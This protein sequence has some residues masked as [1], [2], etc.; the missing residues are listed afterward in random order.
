MFSVKCNKVTC[1]IIFVCPKIL[2]VQ[3]ILAIWNFGVRDVLQKVSLVET[4]GG[5]PMETDFNRHFNF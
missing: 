5:P 3:A 2:N 4:W 1:A